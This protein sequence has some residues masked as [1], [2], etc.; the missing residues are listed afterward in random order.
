MLQYCCKQ[1]KN[2]IN[3]KFHDV[4]GVVVTFCGGVFISVDLVLNVYPCYQFV[5]RSTPNVPKAVQMW[6]SCNSAEQQLFADRAGSL[7]RDAGAELSQH[8]CQQCFVEKMVQKR[9]LKRRWMCGWRLCGHQKH[10]QVASF[11]GALSFSVFV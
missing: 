10:K 3:Q 7:C 1:G 9:G 11:L 6:S 2:D 5:N 8:S 4:R